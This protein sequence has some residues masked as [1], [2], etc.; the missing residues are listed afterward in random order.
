MERSPIPPIP[1]TVRQRAEKLRREI[2]RHR[3]L[4]HVLDRPEISDAALDSLK[5]ELLA[6]EDRY[7]ALVTP[8]SPTQRVGGRA[9][10][11]FMK[12]RHAAPMLSFNDAFTEEELRAWDERWRKLLPKGSTGGYYVELKIDG[13][14]IAMVYRGGIFV[15]GST[16]GDGVIGEDVTLNLKT[17]EAL[18]LRLRDRAD[19]VRDLSREGFRDLA[20]R[21]PSSFPQEIEVRGEAFLTKEEFRC[22][23]RGLGARGGQ[24]YANPR[25]LAAG[26]LRQLDPAVTASRKLDSF[27]YDL[28][29]SLG[30]ETHEETHALLRALGLKTNP[31][32]RRVGTLA[33]VVR[34]RNAWLEKRESLPYE[35]DGIVVQVND[36]GDFRRL[37]AVGKAPRGAVA[38]K[39]PLREATTVVRDITVQVGRTGALTPV[40]VLEPVEVGGVTVTHATL[41]NADEV[42]RLDVRVGDTVIVGRAGDVIPQMRSVVKGL[43]PAGAKPFRT[44]LR[45]PSCKMAAARD[46]G[47]VILRCPNVQCP[48]RHR[49]HLY[50]FAAKPA[51]DIAGLG[52]ETIDK[53]VD[54]GFVRDAADFFALRPDDLLN[55]EGFAEVSARKLVA[56]IQSRKRIELPRFLVA[57]GIPHVGEET[58]QVLAQRFG[59]LRKIAWANERMLR[60]VPD[61]GPIVAEAIAVWFRDRE[62][63]ALLQKFKRAGVR[64]VAHKRVSFKQTL[65]GATVVFTGELETLTRGDAKRIARE[66]GADV[67]E[68]VSRKTSFVVVGRSPG[69]KF[70][71]AK[72]FGVEIVSEADFLKRL[73]RA[74]RPSNSN[75]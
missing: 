4:Y 36:I 7:P 75:P 27:A 37:G 73:G 55:I 22:I 30:Q 31:H 15:E 46:R 40:A 47:G 32:N 33:D 18:P 8:D 28:V 60:A 71:K 50:H 48:G 41:H 43:R 69:A 6:L 67:A 1:E 35:I 10:K 51:L 12:V 21:L 64:T 16:R 34:F 39:F 74:S 59:S 44:P 24:A 63:R 3:Y 65:A 70:E 68:S 19:V 29:T 49:E 9:R 52:A 72:K 14:A 38:F 2:E 61:I 23:N 42:A 11:E 26:S 20:R 66:H 45:C 13:L 53:L 25:N 17:I 58:A 56:A 5:R 54:A 57:L 62:H